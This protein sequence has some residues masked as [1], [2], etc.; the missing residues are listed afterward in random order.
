LRVC[1]PYSNGT[2]RDDGER[3]GGKLRGVLL[4]RG[5]YYTRLIFRL[6]PRQTDQ[7][8]PRP[9]KKALAKSQFPEIIVGSQQQPAFA[10]RQVQ[11]GFV[12]DSGLHLR[13][14]KYV[15]AFIPQTGDE[16]PVY[17]LICDK[18]HPAASRT[19]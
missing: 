12:G 15:M 8:N 5:G 19:G 4:Y 7:N 17:A 3:S 16:L 9:G 10:I 18:V 14:V 1:P 13:Y 2:G 6:E 11:Y